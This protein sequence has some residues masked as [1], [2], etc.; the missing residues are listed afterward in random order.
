MLLLL[1]PKLA[2]AIGSEGL[3]KIIPISQRNLGWE[4]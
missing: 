3:N 1:F 4:N 2:S